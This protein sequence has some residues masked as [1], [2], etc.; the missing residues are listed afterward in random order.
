MG[1]LTK[2][3]ALLVIF[4]LSTIST[5]STVSAQ[6]PLPSGD[7]SITISEFP[8]PDIFTHL[9][10]N[11]FSGN[12]SWTGSVVWCPSCLYVSHVTGYYNE[13]TGEVTFSFG[14]I[15]FFGYVLDSFFDG[16]LRYPVPPFDK[17]SATLDG[18]YVVNPWLAHH[19]ERGWSACTGNCL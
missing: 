7:Y 8:G 6:K 15:T 18:S 11:P 17:G 3:N 13:T 4:V 1:K 14:A 2:V 19:S 5:V 10:I 12:G 9:T 16:R